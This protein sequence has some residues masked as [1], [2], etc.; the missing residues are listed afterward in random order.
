M[1]RLQSRDG[2]IA[3]RV[4]EYPALEPVVVSGLF[5]GANLLGVIMWRAQSDMLG[6]GKDPAGVGDGGR[7]GDRIL[8]H[9]IDRR[10][11]MRVRVWELVGAAREVPGVEGG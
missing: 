2:V 8:Q 6:P 3:L 11:G 7:S 5:L 10:V 1:P 9:M 4:P